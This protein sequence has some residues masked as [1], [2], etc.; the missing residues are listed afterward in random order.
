MYT[1]MYIHT[2]TL[3]MYLLDD[4]NTTLVLK[5]PNKFIRAL[6]PRSICEC[7]HLHVNITA[8]AGK[9]NVQDVFVLYVNNIICM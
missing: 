6:V 5:P 4:R 8:L 3:Y 9:S 1:Y 7:K 2:N